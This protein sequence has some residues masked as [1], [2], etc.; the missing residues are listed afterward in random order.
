MLEIPHSVG[1]LSDPPHIA[2]FPEI[3]DLLLASKKACLRIEGLSM[4]PVL[5]TGDL[6]EVEPLAKKL[7][8]VGDIVVFKSEKGFTCHRL[9][10]IF[11]Q[12][13]ETWIKTKGDTR[14]END[15]PISLPQIL[16]KVIRVERN[17]SS[18]TPAPSPQKLSLR[19]FFIFL[20][21]KKQLSQRPKVI[22]R[23]LFIRFQSSSLFRTSYRHVF[24]PQ[25]TYSLGISIASAMHPKLW[26]YLSYPFNQK[27][28]IKEP[29][30]YRFFAKA[31]ENSVGSLEVKTS[32]GS[33]NEKNHSEWTLS[34]LFVRAQYRGCGI[35]TTL[36]KQAF[37]AL[38]KQGVSTLK[39]GV[40]P[41]NRP[42]RFLFRRLGFEE[43]SEKEVFLFTKDLS[44]SVRFPSTEKEKEDFLRKAAK[45]LLLE[46]A[47][48]EIDA[49]LKEAKVAYLVQKGM[50]IA[51]SLYP[52][53]AMRSMVDIDLYLRKKDISSAVMALK[54]LGYEMRQSE[55]LEELLTFGGELSFY[56]ENS[57]IVEI[58]WCLEQYERLKDIVKIDEKTLW[59][60]AISYEISGRTFKTF[61]PEHQLLSLCIHLGLI[62][63]FRGKKWF[64]DID[65]FVLRFGKDLDWEALFQTARAWGIERIVCQVLLETQKLFDTPLP[66]LSIQKRSLLLKLPAFQ[67]LLLDHPKDRLKVILRAFFPS[68]EWLI[69]RYHLKNRGLASL[70]RFLHPFLV[71]IGI[72]K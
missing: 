41:Q 31:K 19:E 35:A 36:L 27:E 40:K 24:H 63:R 67:W 11:E 37:Q 20:S 52:D 9:V 56:K 25:V 46:Q 16:G 39:V 50:A 6:V 45:H 71:L 47:L 13:G 49:A 4:F 70:Y 22:L 72:T 42:A 3:V 38:R 61:C 65:R 53:P 55:F 69:Y 29:S 7:P 32:E 64:L 28:V 48:F 23:P 43:T 68:R 57:P 15:L 18:W 14:K 60:R 59:D 54:G 1:V 8:K 66:P 2:A 10:E 12:N 30:V 44:S 26:T 34:H 17:G 5:Y 51:Y 21:L 33:S 58:H 62:H